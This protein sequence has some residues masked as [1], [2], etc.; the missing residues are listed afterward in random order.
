MSL[1]N[2][3]NG[4]GSGSGSGMFY[5]SNPFILI[6]LSIYHR[7]FTDKNIDSFF[8]TLGISGN[9]N[10]GGL[11]I[12]FFG[13]MGTGQLTFASEHMGNEISVIRLVVVV[14]VVVV[15]RFLINWYYTFLVYKIMY[16]NNKNKIIL[17]F[18]Y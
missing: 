4:G 11:P 18:N 8:Y 3:P 14:V 1:N 15:F 17:F 6:H 10:L 9:S 12:Q 7:W 16:N 13:Q 5:S 2:M